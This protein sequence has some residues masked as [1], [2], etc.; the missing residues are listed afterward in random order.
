MSKAFFL[1]LIKGLLD[2]NSG[3]TLCVLKEKSGCRDQAFD[4]PEMCLL[5]EPQSNS[6]I[7]KRIQNFR[8][9]IKTKNESF[10]CQSIFTTTFSLI[11][12]LLL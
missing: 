5:L 8:K 6:H 7:G 9:F 2:S 4:G 10:R 11:I 12:T 1:Q 3:L